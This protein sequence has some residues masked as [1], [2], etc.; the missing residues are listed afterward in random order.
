MAADANDPRRA[1]VAPLEGD[2]SRI[3]PGGHFAV[4]GTDNA[5]KEWFKL[6]GGLPEVSYYTVLREGMVVDDGDPSGLYFGT[7]TGQLYASRDRGEHWESVADS[8]PPVYS[9]SVATL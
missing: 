1:Y 2:F 9:V 3:P 8:L 4:W 6:D 7:T 5:G